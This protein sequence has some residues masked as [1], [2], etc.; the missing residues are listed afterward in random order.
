ML[1]YPY[2]GNLV[3]CV[4][5][6]NH[7]R[8][9]FSSYIGCKYK[10]LIIKCSLVFTVF[11]GVDMNTMNTGQIVFTYLPTGKCTSAIMHLALPPPLVSMV[12]ISA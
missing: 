6:V 11:M 4:E 12:L 9:T 7:K 3:K 10:C 8:L 2:L 5:K 1:I